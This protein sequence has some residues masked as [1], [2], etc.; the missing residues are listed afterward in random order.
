MDR[1]RIE[2]DCRVLA[3]R[4]ALLT[5]REAPEYFDKTLFSGYLDTLVEIGLAH[6]AGDH[7]EVEERITRM[8]NRSL[9][10]LGEETRGTLLHLLARRRPAPKPTAMASV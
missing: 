6:Q 10:L 4:L 2:R 9:E 1:A 7:F 3:E 5:G 8:A